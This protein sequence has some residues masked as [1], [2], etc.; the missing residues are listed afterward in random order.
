MLE[1]IYDQQMD[2]TFFIT[3]VTAQRR[4]IFRHDPTATLFMET[5]LHY[6]SQ[7]KYLLHEFVIMPDHF[8]ALITPSEEISLEK[9]IQFIKGRFSH[10]LHSRI[11]VWQGGFTNHRIRDVED[12]E[13]HREYIRMNPVR[14]RLADRPGKYSYSSAGQA[15]SLDPPPQGLKPGLLAG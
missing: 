3:S 15:I 4:P 5:L 11:P 12:F 10:R 14:A 9:A 7:S 13:H 6:R 8:H 1:R 2:R